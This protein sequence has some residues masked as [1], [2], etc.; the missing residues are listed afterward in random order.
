[1]SCENQRGENREGRTSRNKL[2]II[3]GHEIVAIDAPLKCVSLMAAIGTTFTL[4][5]QLHTDD[6]G[7]SNGRF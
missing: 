1:M 3:E 4:W 7:A 2:T 6:E 5:A